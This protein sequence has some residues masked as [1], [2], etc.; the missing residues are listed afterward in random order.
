MKKN[1]KGVLYIQE[2]DLGIIDP[3]AIRNTHPNNFIAAR[4]EYLINLINSKEWIIDYDKV[5]R[6][7]LEEL[8]ALADDAEYQIHLLEEELKT[9]TD[10]IKRKDI[11]IEIEGLKNK[12]KDLE[13]IY[14]E[15]DKNIDP[16]QKNVRT[17]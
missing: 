2:K 17:I 1:I 13:T 9:V 5:K 6:Y 7:D 3:K 14:N 12:I 16:K 8:N 10:E 4:D 15:I 11:L